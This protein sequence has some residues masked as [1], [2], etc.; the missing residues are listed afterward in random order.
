MSGC[1]KC[2]RREL[3]QLANEV[4]QDAR[5]AKQ[6]LNSTDNLKLQGK[7]P[8]DL[9]KSGE[10]SAD[11][12]TKELYIAAAND[13]A[14]FD[15]ESY[16]ARVERV[17]K[18]VSLVFSM[19]AADAIAWMNDRKL[20]L[21]SKTPKEALKDKKTARRLEDALIRVRNGMNT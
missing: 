7:K 12:V 2:K 10:V 1:M 5:R 9:I 19:N 21:S 18:T 3:T 16:D 13:P 8:I 15:R 14:Q 6:W 20:A 11:T 17:E 4:F